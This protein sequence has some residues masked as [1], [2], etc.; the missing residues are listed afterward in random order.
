VTEI[1]MPRLSDTM[2]E[3]TIARWLKRPGDP[4]SKGDVIAEIETDKATMDLEVY[5]DG[6]LESILV[7]EGATVPIG[8]PIGVIGTTGPQ[9]APARAPA[10]TAVPGDAP[11]GAQSPPSRASEPTS[12]EQRLDA[13][14]PRSSPLARAL[15]RR[16]G[17]ALADIPG[18]GPGGRVVRVDVENA[19]AGEPGHL[20]DEPKR[21]APPDAQ[22]I[23]QRQGPPTSTRQILADDIEEVPLGT[24]RR[25]TAE[26]LTQS[27]QTPH[28]D[29]TSV[30]DA[31]P[32]VVFRSETNHSLSSGSAKISFTDLLIKSCAKVLS[33]HPEMNASWGGDKLLRHHNV[34]IGVAVAVPDGLVV[35]VIHHAD[36]KTLTQISAEAHALAERARNGRISVDDMTGGTFTISNLGM[37]GVDHFTAIINPPQAAI[38]AVGATIDE[39]VVRDGQV[40]VGTTLKVTLSVDHRVLDGATAAAFLADL[41]DT[42]QNPLRIVV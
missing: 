27:A 14:E 38:L 30:I 33:A 28:F 34:H 25:L 18:T 41:R 21:P 3:G 23:G 4:V 20:R 8:R 39:P 7:D 35:P 40:V 29:L 17:I 12:P 15:A 10:G 31:A 9:S 6:V 11:P 32:L 1:I 26:R 22:P 13:S 24:V 5:E 37:Y 36:Q 2:E 42:L 19:I 16:H